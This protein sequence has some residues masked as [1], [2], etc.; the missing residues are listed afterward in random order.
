MRGD[1][2]EQFRT[3]PSGLGMLAGVTDQD[4][5]VRRRAPMSHQSGSSPRSRNHVSVLA[6]CCHLPP[7]DPQNF[8]SSAAERL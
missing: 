8:H 2:E 1:A 6:A 5:F 4:D 3:D 7:L